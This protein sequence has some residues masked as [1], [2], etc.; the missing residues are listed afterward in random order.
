VADLRVRVLNRPQITS[1]GWTA[2]PAAIDLAFAGNADFATA[3]EGVRDDAGER[4]G[5]PVLPGENRAACALHIAHYDLC[6]YHD[7]PPLHAGDGAGVTDHIWSVG[8]DRR[9]AFSTRAVAAAA[10]ATETDECC[11]GE[12]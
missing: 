7:H 11:R 6:R 8:A 12:G 5:G 2:Y 9:G 3:R 4:G 1:D 10:R